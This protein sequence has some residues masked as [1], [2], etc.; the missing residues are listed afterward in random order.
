M[1]SGMGR[2]L[3]ALLAMSAIGLAAV[4]AHASKLSLEERGFRFTW[5]RLEVKFTYAEATETQI[6]CP[7]TLQGSFHSRTLAKARGALIGQVSTASVAEASCRAAEGSFSGKLQALRTLPWHVTYQGF[8]G[9]LPLIQTIRIRA[10]G[11][12][13]RV[14]ELPT[15]GM[16]VDNS[17]LFASTAETPLAFNVSVNARFELV[18]VRMEEAGPNMPFSTGGL[19]CGSAP[20]QIS[21]TA[22][23]TRLASVTAIALRLI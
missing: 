14:Y 11:A 8:T 1:R 10:A 7:V 3:A 18:N 12:A 21:G 6:G 22:F 2:G 15:F 5:T 17:C 16:P 4:G 13:F 9:T 19:F 20:L 23:V